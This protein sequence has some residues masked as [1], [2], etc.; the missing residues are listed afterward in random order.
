MPKLSTTQR[1][2]RWNKYQDSL[3]HPEPINPF[4]DLR[5]ASDWTMVEICNRAGISKQ[6]LIRTEQGTYEYPPERLL[7]FWSNEGT[8]YTE[9]TTRYEQFQLD[10]RRRH[11]YLFGRSSYWAFTL[12]EHP[13]VTLLTSHWCD[14]LDREYLGVMNATECAK[15]L[16]VN[17]S[18]VD[19][20][21]QK[22]Q[23]QK[24]VPAPLLRALRQNGYTLDDLD[25][26]S[27]AY[28]DYRNH[29]L[30]GIDPAP[31]KVSLKQAILEELGSF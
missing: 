9:L 8:S 3:P 17:Q 24:S 12:S 2:N 7:D 23:R 15:L 29:T 19:H 14:A 25:N 28:V 18:V 20:F 13:F 1:D 5:I 10:T 11:S 22:P 4:K 30:Y 6:A 27:Q 16:C 26:L 21:V 31:V